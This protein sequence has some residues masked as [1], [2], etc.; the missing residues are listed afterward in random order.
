MMPLTRRFILALTLALLAAPPALASD[1]GT[2]PPVIA[3]FYD[4]LLAVM[5]EAKR[6][7]FDERYN[8]LAPAISRSFDLPLMTRIAVGPGWAQLSPDQQQR[9]AAAF[10][11]YTISM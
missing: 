9:L 10:S 2:A 11:R 1:P 6:L 8:R 4:D 3:H 7:S 5:K